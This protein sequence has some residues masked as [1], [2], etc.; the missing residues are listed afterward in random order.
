MPDALALRWAPIFDLR[1]FSS[2]FS[3]SFHKKDQERSKDTSKFVSF[4]PKAGLFEK[5]HVF[6]VFALGLRARHL[7]RLWRSA[8]GAATENLVDCVATVVKK[9]TF[10]HRNF[11][12]RKNLQN[13]QK[14]KKAKKRPAQYAL[15]H[16]LTKSAV[17]CTVKSVSL[18]LLKGLSSLGRPFSHC[19]CVIY[20]CCTF[21]FPR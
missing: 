4:L 15:A 9:F 5:L 19:C 2:K 8:F 7:F 10:S 1:H 14:V 3:F 12:G 16:V 11:Q 20:F 13:F 6:V 21:Q 17:D 18:R